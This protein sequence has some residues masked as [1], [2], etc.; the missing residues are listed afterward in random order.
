MDGKK[1]SKSLGN[2]IPLR[3]AIRIYGADTLRVSILSASE[4]LQ[5]ADFSDSLA[6][7]T[8]SKLQEFFTLALQYAGARELDRQF[9]DPLDRWL[10]SRVQKTIAQTTASMDC[11]R[12]REAIQTA[13][14]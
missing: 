11:L 6:R 10:L 13:F 1:M 9:M 7:G 4:L 2:I 14:F 8:R 5:D 12:V 3:K